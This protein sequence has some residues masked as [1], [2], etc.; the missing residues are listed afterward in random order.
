ML[1][2]QLQKGGFFGIVL[3]VLLLPIVT[4]NQDDIP[5]LD[6]MAEKSKTES[7][8]SFGSP[9]ENPRFVERLRDV[10]FDCV[11]LGWICT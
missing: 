6:E 3:A 10:I 7:V 1:Q 4:G 11:R 9:L 2:K 5:D 8:V